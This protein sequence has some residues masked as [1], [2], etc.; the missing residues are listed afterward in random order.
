MEEDFK[1]TRNELLR[2]TKHILAKY[3]VKPKKKLGQS[4]TIDPSLLLDLVAYADIQPT[5]L[6]LEV[7]AGVG[8]LTRLL[9]EKARKVIAIEVDSRLVKALREVFKEN[10][11]VE[12]VEGD[13]LKMYGLKADK[14]VSTVPYSIA[15]PF[16]FKLLK[17]VDFKQAILTFQKE[18]AER[19]IAKP[20]S[21]DY[22]RL[23][24]TTSYY[25]D[26]KL[27]RFVSRRC[28]YPVP[29]VDSAIVEVKRRDKPPFRVNEESFMKLVKILFSQRNRIALSVLKRAFPNL[30]ET[31]L[32]ISLASKR[33][34]EL[35]MDD[36]YKAY[37]AVYGAHGHGA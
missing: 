9:A 2:Y 33:V 7:G 25:A 15:S 10:S 16:T 8:C 26:V 32:P 24:V 11:N 36:L 23:T 35:T 5:D 3:E 19:L 6:V 31:D 20:G 12:V 4:F 27:L 37:K 21:R 28:F 1:L 34:R 29:D 17:E 14:V 18:F 30:N 13:F 22:G